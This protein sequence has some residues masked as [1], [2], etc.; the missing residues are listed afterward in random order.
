MKRIKKIGKNI[1]NIVY[2]R[3]C[4]VCGRI[5]KDQSLLA[6]PG[7]PQKLKVVSD[8]YCMKCGVPVSEEEEFCLDCRKRKRG[9][10][11]GRSVYLYDR[12]MQ[13][14]VLQFKKNGVREYREFYGAAIVRYLEHD[15]RR[16][17]PDVL[18]P[19]PLSKKSLKRRGFNQACDI[20]LAM[21][22]R[23]QIPVAADLL[24]KKKNTK[25]QK[26]LD[27]EQR[28]KNL[29]DAFG[30]DE[31]LDGLRILLVDD[32]YTTGSTMESAAKTLKEAGAAEVYFVTLSTG[33]GDA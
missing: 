14:S 10:L 4:P 11:K 8:H 15:I 17:N 29:K 3:K 27:A 18:V 23:M 7:C 25:E 30:T 6:C 13:R 32:V 22:K 26:S 12:R 16:W 5:L 28:R 20:A 21:E 1:L 31:R 9:F 33:H 24:Y 2:P 19:V